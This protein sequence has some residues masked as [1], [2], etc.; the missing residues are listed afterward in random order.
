MLDIV[1]SG[2]YIMATGPC[3]LCEE[4]GVE[5][6]ATCAVCAVANGTELAVRK[7]RQRHFQAHLS[8]SGPHV[9][10]DTLL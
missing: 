9:L 8:H 4:M 3:R 5:P 6:V 1:A 10:P 2:A 7:C